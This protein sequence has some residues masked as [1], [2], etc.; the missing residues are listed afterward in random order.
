MNKILAI[1]FVIFLFVSDS[2]SQKEIIDKVVANVGSEVVLLSDVEDQYAM[3]EAQQGTLPEG[4]RC[5]IM[6]NILI[7]KLLVNQA[8]L[9]SI[10][11]SDDEVEAQLKA[12]IDQILAYMNNDVSQFEA[13]YG[14]S[15]AAVK[16]R[17]RTDLRNQLLADRMKQKIM[18]TIPITPI[19][20]KEF[21]DRIPKDSLPYFSAEVE[22]AELVMKPKVNDIE[23]QKAIDKLNDI[24]TK[25]KAGEDFAELANKYSDDPGSGH[26]GG[27]LGWTK[28]G[29]FVPEF[30][31][32]AYR[33]EVGEISP[34]I[35]TEFGFH[36]IQLIERRGNSI[37][38]RHILIKPEITDDDLAL[39]AAKLDSIRTLLLADSMSFTLAV[40]KFGE[41]SVQSYNNNGRVVN[42][43]TGNT[44]FEIGDLEPDIYFAID[45]LDVGG[46]TAPY[47]FTD[48]TG[49]VFYRILKLESQTDPHTANLKQD[50]SKIK[51]AAIEEK[52]NLFTTNWIQDMINSTFFRIDPQFSDCSILD[53]WHASD[54]L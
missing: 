44:F 24:L 34:I 37:H 51:K 48:R 38:T 40:K 28:R 5:N 8:K 21:F 3:M 49:T 19:E 32:A 45:T 36:I 15:I 27:D 41:K 43:K 30:E 33:L 31:A 13:Y 23:K 1:I 47:T 25:I 50:Y 20:V 18:G 35:E 14:Q 11:V 29:S 22:I 4:F 42:P 54:K 53:K 17:F 7:Q 46:I 9:D 52:K 6:D 12:R 10:E 39:T 16:E 2:F 26:M